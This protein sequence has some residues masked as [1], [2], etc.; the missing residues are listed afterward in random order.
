MQK[1]VLVLRALASASARALALANA[2]ARAL[3][4]AHALAQVVQML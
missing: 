1:V 3:A 4:R 2:C